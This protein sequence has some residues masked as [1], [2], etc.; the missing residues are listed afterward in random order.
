MKP[1]STSDSCINSHKRGRGGGW[2]GEGWG[3]AGTRNPRMSPGPEGENGGWMKRG[4]RGQLLDGGMD[5]WWQ[6][7]ASRLR[8]VAALQSL[9]T[10]I[11]TPTVTHTHTC[12]Y[13]SVKVCES[14]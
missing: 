7:R 2:D 4:E 6:K 11:P 14:C 8:I 1:S 9:H 12:A 3:D 13:M 10:Q 5:Q